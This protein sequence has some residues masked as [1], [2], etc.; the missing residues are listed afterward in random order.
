MGT[1]HS[2]YVANNSGQDIY[3]M[4][5]LNPDWAIVDIGLLAYGVEEIKGVD[6]AAEL[7]E[8]LA[9][10]RDLYDFLNIARKLLIGMA[11]TGSRPGEAALALINAFKRTAIKISN[12][13]CKD[14]E[15]IVS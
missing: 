11:A 5:S 8:T 2:V 3:V 4:A 15:K 10:L 6:M 13:D 14:V 1:S 12:G 9:T 7:P